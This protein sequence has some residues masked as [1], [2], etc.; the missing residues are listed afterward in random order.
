MK[1]QLIYNAVYNHFLEE[2]HGIQQT[3]S[4]SNNMN[5]RNVFGKEKS[6]FR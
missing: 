1:L 4:F 3:W 2:E 5:I 6:R